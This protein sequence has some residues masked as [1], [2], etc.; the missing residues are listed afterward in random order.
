MAYAACLRR[1][2]IIPRAPKLDDDR[3]HPPPNSGGAAAG[4]NP[5]G[6]LRQAGPAHHPQSITN[7]LTAKGSYDH[8]ARGITKQALDTFL[9]HNVCVR[10]TYATPTP[11]VDILIRYPTS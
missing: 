4:A 5:S 2:S 3:G 7:G 1:E 6:V 9:A 11:L 10:D 8:G